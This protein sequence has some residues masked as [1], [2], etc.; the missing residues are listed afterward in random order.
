MVL[1][2][3]LATS[4]FRLRLGL[5][6]SSY[7]CCCWKTY[8]PDL[9]LQNIQYLIVIHSVSC[10]LNYAVHHRVSANSS[11]FPIHD[12]TLKMQASTHYF[13]YC[14]EP[15]QRLKK[16]YNKL[17]FLNANG[18]HPLA[19]SNW[20]RKHDRVKRKHDIG[21]RYCH[22]HWG[23]LSV[24]PPMKDKLSQ[25]QICDGWRP[26]DIWKRSQETCHG[27]T[28]ENTTWNELFSSI[29]QLCFSLLFTSPVFSSRKIRESRTKC[30]PV[31]V[32][33]EQ[34]PLWT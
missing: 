2:V 1:W 10:M 16:G 8:R 7:F 31:T 32:H 33:H 28:Q 24:S 6:S 20:K 30:S 17:F 19:F 13:I 5:L 29:S 25:L 26:R 21:V 15:L 12:F 18:L 9:V 14:N 4:H 27:Y 3:G 23:L 11:I 22:C 34:H